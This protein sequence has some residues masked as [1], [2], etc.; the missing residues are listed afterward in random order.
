MFLVMQILDFDCKAE[1]GFLCFWQFGL[2]NLTH[3]MAQS[4]W[5]ADKMYIL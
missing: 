2:Y 1:L 3:T 5:E 4:N